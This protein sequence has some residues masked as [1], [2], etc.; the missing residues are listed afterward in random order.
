M[1]TVCIQT[2]SDR[3]LIESLLYSSHSLHTCTH[4]FSVLRHRRAS[5]YAMHLFPTIFATDQLHTLNKATRTLHAV[6][7][8]LFLCLFIHNAVVSCAEVVLGCLVLVLSLSKQYLKQTKR[9]CY[10]NKVRE[11][12]RWSISAARLWLHIALQIRC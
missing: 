7:Y 3:A 11:V 10:F 2:I 9:Y 5:S 8:V 1:L 12:F 4:G 6:R